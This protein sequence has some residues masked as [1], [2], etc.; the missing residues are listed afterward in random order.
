MRGR[1]FPT[2][3]TVGVMA[4]SSLT[5]AQTAAPRA[6][7][8]QK[9][10][11]DLRTA[12]ANC[13]TALETA[14][15]TAP[16]VCAEAASLTE[17]LPSDRRL[18]RRS[19]RRNLA[20][21]FYLN[22]QYAEARVQMERAIVSSGLTDISA[23]AADDYRDLA[24]IQEAL[25]DFAAAD[26]TFAR[27]VRTYETA[28]VAIGSPPLVEQYRLRLRQ[29]L[30]EYIRLKRSQGDAAGAAALEAKAAGLSTR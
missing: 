6:A 7:E 16:T 26:A 23:D 15:S 4:V 25:S 5:F 19:A 9:L 21:A 29:T 27:A 17:R 14:I 30:D 11:A 28:I 3:V 2:A 12:S 18:E 20:S 13:R 10:E 22:K 8:A 24:M 1:A